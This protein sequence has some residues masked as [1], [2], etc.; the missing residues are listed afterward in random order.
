MAK[1]TENSET[2]ERVDDETL[3]TAPP[4]IRN[5]QL[6]K[7]ML[8]S[9]QAQH[10]PS[11]WSGEICGVAVLQKLHTYLFEHA[12]QPYD[13]WGYARKDGICFDTCLLLTPA[14]SKFLE[15]NYRNLATPVTITIPPYTDADI[16][17]LSRV[18]YHG[19]EKLAPKMG[20]VPDDYDDYLNHYY[21]FGFQIIRYR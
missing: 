7:C 6:T 9:K 17:E 19:G 16:K 12:T 13:S 2:P 3:R 1:E 15:D 5:I 14:Q 21:P 20:H 8:L 10:F 11:N 18:I 4:A